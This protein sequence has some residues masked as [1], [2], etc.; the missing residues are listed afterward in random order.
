MRVSLLADLRGSGFEPLDQQAM[1]RLEGGI[2]WALYG[3]AVG[4]YAVK[5]VAD[6]WGDFKAGV[7]RGLREMWNGF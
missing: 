6:N 4:I 2:P 7:R 1:V 3:Y 5:T